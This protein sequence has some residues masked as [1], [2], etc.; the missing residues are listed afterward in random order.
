MSKTRL[1]TPAGKAEDS[2][3]ATEQAQFISQWEPLCAELMGQ[4]FGAR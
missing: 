4:D 3:G 1:E 2:C